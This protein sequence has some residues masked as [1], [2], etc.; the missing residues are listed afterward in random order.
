MKYDIQHKGMADYW[1]ASAGVLVSSGGCSVDDGEVI[2][3]EF[4]GTPGP[5]VAVSNGV[6]IDICQ[7]SGKMIGNTCASGYS[8]DDGDATNGVFA[9]ANSNLIAAAPEL[10]EAL[11]LAKHVIETMLPAKSASRKRVCDMA[12]KAIN[13]ALGGDCE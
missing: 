4:K 12:G 13:K 8:F 5:W 7:E 3:S 10:L 6:F 9:V 11:Q 2:V 1:L